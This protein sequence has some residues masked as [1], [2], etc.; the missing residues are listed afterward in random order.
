MVLQAGGNTETIA[1]H[2]REVHY[3]LAIACDLCKSFTRMSAPIILE[4]WSGCK[5]KHSIEHTE[6]GHEVKKLHKKKP[7]V[8]DQEKASYSQFEWHWWILQCKKTPN[9]FRSIPLMNMGWSSHLDLVFQVSF[10]STIQL[11]C[12][13][14]NMLYSTMVLWFYLILCFPRSL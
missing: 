10:Q 5:V 11:S 6:Q 7:K 4:H 8:R 9:T 3:W 14:D 12:F 2:L 1:T 13:K